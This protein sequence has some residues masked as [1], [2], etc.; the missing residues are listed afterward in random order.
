MSPANC[1]C[2]RKFAISPSLDKYPLSQINTQAQ[3]NQTKT[4]EQNIVILDAKLIWLKKRQSNLVLLHQL[5]K[6]TFKNTNSLS[7]V[8]KVNE[9]YSCLKSSEKNP[10]L[11]KLM[12]SD[13]NEVIN[14]QKKLLAQKE[15]KSVKVKC[16]FAVRKYNGF[17]EKNKVTGKKGCVI[18]H[19]RHLSDLPASAH[20]RLPQQP[21][22]HR[23]EIC[24]KKGGRFFISKKDEKEKE[25]IP[26]NEL[27]FGIE[28]SK[29]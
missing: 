10:V 2:P 20:V 24:L 7:K 16:A 8:L 19:Q 11:D 5:P 22:T 3:Q 13:T 28:N 26:E 4:M 15:I 9:K 12:Q 29:I 23:P 25:E 14:A 17:L 21:Q 27:T 18:F 6:K 1:F